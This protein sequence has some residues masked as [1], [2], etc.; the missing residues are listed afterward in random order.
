MA[1]FNSVWVMI[2]C[3]P[4]HILPIN[5]YDLVRTWPEMAAHILSFS[6]TIPAPQHL[7]ILLHVC[8]VKLEDKLK[9]ILIR[10]S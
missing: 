8:L 10:F 9:I 4:A 2:H 7:D 6:F 5:D 3:Q 1:K